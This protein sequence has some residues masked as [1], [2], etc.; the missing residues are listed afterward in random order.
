MNII[1]SKGGITS[2]LIEGHERFWKIDKKRNKKLL[3]NWIYANSTHTIDLLRFFGGDYKKIYTLKK[4]FKQK[5][6]DHFS[7]ILRSNKNIIATYISNWYSPDGWS[8]N[9]FGNGI[10]I[11]YNPL[12]IDKNFKPGFYEQM[13]SFKSL[14]KSKKLKWPAQDMTQAFKSVELIR[15]IIN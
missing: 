5:N 9:L 4:S 6:G 14:I 8:I 12:K 15:K 10:T 2:I 7:M 11:I 1:N 3:E 13:I